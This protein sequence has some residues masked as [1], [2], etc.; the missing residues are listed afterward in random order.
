MVIDLVITVVTLLGDK[1]LEVSLFCPVIVY[2]NAV[3][4]GCLLHGKTSP[5]PVLK[6]YFVITALSHLHCYA[7]FHYEY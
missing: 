3:V 5:S 7:E 2:I 1:I 6:I 4:I